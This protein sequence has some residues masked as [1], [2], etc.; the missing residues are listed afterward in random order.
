MLFRKRGIVLEKGIVLEE[1]AWYNAMLKLAGKPLENHKKKFHAWT[2]HGISKNIN[3]H[4][5]LMKFSEI[6]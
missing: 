1:R 2:N 4:G 3:Y 6:I 5:K